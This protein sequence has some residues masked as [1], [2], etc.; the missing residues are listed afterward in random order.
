M[1]HLHH[2]TRTEG[3]VFEVAALHP[4]PRRRLPPW[5][6]SD[7]SCDHHIDILSYNH[8][9]CW[10]NELVV[11]SNVMSREDVLDEM[12]GERVRRHVEHICW[13]IPHRAAGSANGKR[14]AEYSR[15]SLISAGVSCTEMLELPA[16]VSFPE[17]AEFRVEA[18]VQIAIQANTLGHSVATMPEGLAGELVYVG[19]GDFAD[20]EG[21]NV[22][23][24]IILTE[25]SYSPARHEKQRI[26][27]LLGNAVC[28]REGS[29]LAQRGNR[30]R[31]H[32]H[33]WAPR[34]LVE[35]VFVLFMGPD[36]N[37]LHSHESPLHRQAGPTPSFLQRIG[38]R[39]RER[40]GRA[41]ARR[42]E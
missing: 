33:P 6:R 37:W 19:S 42:A 28:S 22:R 23:G 29:G 3:V 36:P 40:K 10:S 30:R 4:Q 41:E 7:F 5:R 26:A 14:M 16:I 32:S 38:Q 25:L 12:S 27:G 24:K 8:S 20:Y 1:Y 2:D 11:S 39:S 15:D 21:K 31:S 35:R 13:Q 9:V 34:V 18:P 17:H